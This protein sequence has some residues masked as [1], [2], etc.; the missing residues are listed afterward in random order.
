MPSTQLA[1][2]VETRGP[3]ATGSLTKDT[4]FPSILCVTVYSL[5][6]KM[7]LSVLKAATSASGSLAS[8]CS[9]VSEPLLLEGFATKKRTRSDKS[10]FGLRPPRRF[11]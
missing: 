9:S 10:G 7:R 1:L 6:V 5:T 2:V 3:E 4:L 11:G 8:S